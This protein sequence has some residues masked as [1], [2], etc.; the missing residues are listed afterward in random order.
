MSRKPTIFSERNLS[1]VA[2]SLH[3]QV[4]RVF[5]D[6]DTNIQKVG[7]G[8]FGDICNMMQNTIRGFQSY[9]MSAKGPS[10]SAEEQSTYSGPTPGA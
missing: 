1:S 7:T 10:V 3:Q 9:M 6:L 4:S 5:R 2:E 8:E